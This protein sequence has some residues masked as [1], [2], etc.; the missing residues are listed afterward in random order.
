LKQNCGYSP[1]LAQLEH[2][3]HCSMK[4]AIIFNELSGSADEVT[5]QHV[6]DLFKD[7]KINP[8]IYCINKGESLEQLVK[9]AVE[10]GA[11]TIVAAGGDGTI[12]SI[13]NEILKHKNVC[14]GVLPLGTFNN[15]AKTLGIPLEIDL[16]VNT[17][18]R[19]NITQI[20]VGEVNGHIFINNS[21]IGVYPSIVRHREWLQE[22]GHSK[23]LALFFAVLRA[24]FYCPFL[25]L[26]FILNGQKI[27]RKTPL[28]FIG[29]NEYTITGSEIG[30]REHL[31]KRKLSLFITHSLNHFRFLSLC[32]AL[33][34]S[35]KDGLTTLD[36][37]N[38]DQFTIVSR[39]RRLR[40]SLDGEV[41][42]LPTPLHYRILPKALSVISI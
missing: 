17:L 8:Q 23:K 6:I 4:W 39:K 22:Q 42:K 10:T 40:V 19:G 37:I 34:L 5:Q 21:G 28:V 7:H 2:H 26:D 1:V 12:S 18:I 31:N 30:T 15:F 11:E 41:L 13:V 32:I 38:T 27:S 35:R 16:A 9:R 20:D 14:L 24:L 25:H 3:H 29:N 36:T 33:L